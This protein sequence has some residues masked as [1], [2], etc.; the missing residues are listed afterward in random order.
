MRRLLLHALFLLLVSS[1]L[2]AA[3]PPPIIMHTGQPMVQLQLI[4]PFLGANIQYEE[5]RE[6]FFIN[7][8]AYRGWCS[9]DQAVTQGRDSQQQVDCAMYP[10]FP[11]LL[12]VSPTFVHRQLRTL[13]YWD[14]ERQELLLFN[15][16]SCI[17]ATISNV[18]P[19]SIPKA[20]GQHTSHQ[21]REPWDLTVLRDVFARYPELVAQWGP[22]L[23]ANAI[24]Y[25][26][27]DGLAF[28]LDQGVAA[29]VDAVQSALG[30]AHDAAAL[31][32]LER[33]ADVNMRDKD[34]NPIPLLNIAMYFK[35][36][37][38][39]AALLERGAIVNDQSFDCGM[40]PLFYA[41]FE[42]DEEMIRQLLAH[43]ADV[44]IRMIEGRTPLLAM[45]W[46]LGEEPGLYLRLP[47]KHEKITHI[48]TMLLDAGADVNAVDAQG[49]NALLY[50]V[51]LVH[52]DLFHTLLERGATLDTTKKP[53]RS[54]LATLLESAIT[55]VLKYNPSHSNARRILEA[56][57]V[58]EEDKELRARLDRLYQYD[59]P[60]LFA[61][62]LKRGAHVRAI[63][64]D[65]YTPL[66]YAAALKDTTY[67]KRL[68]EL[69]ADVNAAPHCSRQCTRTT[70]RLWHYCSNTAL[71]P[72]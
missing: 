33:V 35:C 30:Q 62:L 6:Q 70:S 44:N 18:H 47:A 3:D 17:I 60:M 9:V 51:G 71:M 65:G 31:L 26:D 5:K 59:L 41:A 50:A 49:N 24:R 7:A 42:L 14:S 39:A 46:F 25:N 36:P 55:A 67:A 72:M 34:G 52:Y 29:D 27:L 57:V 21:R 69:G 11:G 61:A 1:P 48:V 20:P 63:D 12:Y 54:A 13:A 58:N 4:A 15:Q 68:L 45:L 38:T 23:R 32:L 28:L 56:G 64:S 2:F 19:P 53:G 66:R 8:P 37:K 40:T 22:A 43:G 16:A 10:T